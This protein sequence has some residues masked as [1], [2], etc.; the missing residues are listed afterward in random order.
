MAV[1]LDRP[2]GVNPTLARTLVKMRAQAR[3][4]Q[5]Q[6]AARMKTTQTAIARLE[7][8]RQSPTLQTLQAYASA[9]GYC[10]E[11]SFVGHPNAE[12]TGCIVSIEF[13]AAQQGGAGSAGAL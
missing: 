2:M 8:G 10:L 9:S 13:D 6:I 11:I 7:S 1:R 5:A 12:A 3:L 4:T